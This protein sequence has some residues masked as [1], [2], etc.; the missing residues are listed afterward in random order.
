[1]LTLILKSLND[2]NLRCTY[3]S[4]GK[5]T[6]TNR[7]SE[8]RMSEALAFFASYAQERGERC[9]TV[10][11]HG[12][13]PMLLPAEQYDRC[14]QRVREQFPEL[15]FRFSL[16]TN[17]TLLSPAY[18]ALFRKYD[19]HVGVSVDGSQTVHDGQRKSIS[20]QGTY[21]Q[22]LAHIRTL[23]R[24]EVAVAALMVLTRPALAESL[25]FLLEFAHL[26]LPLKI[27][28]LLPVGEAVEHP[29]LVLAPGEYGRYL[30]RVLEY[31]S[32]RRLDLPISP[33]DE[34]FQNILYKGARRGCQ[35][36]PNCHGSFLSIDPAG[37]IYPC[38]RFA[39]ARENA[40]GTIETG[41]TADGRRILE[42]LALRRAENLPPPCRECRYL[43]LC[44]G[45][46][47]AD[48]PWSRAVDNPCIVCQD[49]QYIFHYIKTQGME[50]LRQQLLEERS[51]LLSRIQERVIISDG[52]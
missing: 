26:N 44:H 45:G 37:D 27:N 36:S 29:E 34:I 40:I 12:G 19:I 49:Y 9:V 20:G 15:S 35:H 3:C 38:G 30:A 10:I 5:K 18:V 31:L 46:C 16:Q 23:Q 39:D 2:C 50:L 22:V 14:I 25:N 41:I 17:G 33:L 4:V 21:E 8:E 28:P 52:I 48:Q 24:E 13:E 47:S 6:C 43:E 7:L 32:E 51:S 11:F 1:M 42:R